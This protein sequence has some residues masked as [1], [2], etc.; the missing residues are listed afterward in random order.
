MEETF[1][2][3]VLD[4]VHA[5]HVGQFR[6]VAS[7]APRGRFE[8]D[9]DA[10]YVRT[11]FL[12]LNIVFVARRSADP[13]LIA[14][15]AR[16]FFEGWTDPWKILALPE[17]VDVARRVAERLHLTPDEPLP[18]LIL[19]PLEPPSAPLPKGLTLDRVEDLATFRKFWA[20]AA[21]GF[22]IP[23][24]AF[25]EFLTEDL[26]PRVLAFPGL[27]YYIASF[28]GRPA[29]TVSRY[30]SHG[31]ANI[32]NV[33]T[34]QEFRGRGIGSIISL[35]ATQEGVHEGCTT[36]GTRATK[37]GFPVY[38]KVGFQHAF[39]YAVWASKG[40]PP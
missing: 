25:G 11:G 31:V 33:T 28:E 16:R 9:A 19:D 4:R 27:T 35:H 30:A 38:Q 2:R 29:G 21:E 17:A 8:E 40:A 23:I 36:G 5:N 26:L 3:D 39:S 15:H 6:A 12:D 18:Q 22:G 7:M 10:A 1:G 20:T 24:S 14:D 34:L 37:M 13:D 32:D